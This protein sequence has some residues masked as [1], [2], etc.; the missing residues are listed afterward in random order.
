M[1]STLVCHTPLP[2]DSSAFSGDYTYQMDK[3]SCVR[4]AYFVHVTLAYLATFSGL[5]AL[6]TR[7]WLTRFHS[8]FGKLYIVCMLWCMGTSLL[9]HNTGLPVAVLVSFVWVLGGITVGWLGIHIHIKTGYQFW[10]LKLV[11]GAMMFMSWS[12]ILGRLFSSDQSGDFSCYSYHVYKPID[13]YKF[14]G[15]NRPWVFVPENDP[16]F[17]K[18]PW[19]TTGLAL[20]GALLSIGPL[21]LAFGVFVV[22]HYC[23]HKKTNV[24]VRSELHLPPELRP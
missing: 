20:W 14:Q 15:L 22:V 13:S 10:W 12:N 21:T 23:Y 24:V 5:G 19:A 2:P 6:L 18:L 4:G 1:N 16:N 9:I 11:H 7:I 8:S 3:L 17:G